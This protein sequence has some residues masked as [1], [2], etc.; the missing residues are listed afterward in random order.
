VKLRGAVFGC[1]MISEYHLAAWNRIPEVEIVALGNRTLSRAEQRRDQFAPYARVYSDIAEMLDREHPDFIDIL[2]APA[3]HREHC[4][5][6]REAGV[7][8]ICQKP[9][10][11]TLEDAFAIASMTAESDKLFAVHENHRYRPWFQ[12]ARQGVSTGKYGDIT[13]AKFEH[14]NATS[15]RELY[16][17]ESERGILL[18]YGSHLIDMMRSVLGEPARVYA[19]AHR[20]TAA[21][22]GESLAHAVFEYPSATAVV[23]VGWKHAAI[24]Q[25]SVLLSGTAGE[26][27]FE[28]T[29]TRGD[30]GRFRITHGGQVLLDEPRRPMSDYVES[31]YLLE[32][33]CVDV[34]LGRRAAPE[35]TAD[36]HLKT[37]ACTFAAYESIET[38]NIVETAGYYGRV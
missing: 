4:T 9:L 27:L 25:S 8:I 32:R 3:Q 2:T 37:L 18:E 33:E 38:G 1:G 7:H 19:R 5:I 36:E 15:P 11:E 28:G 30:A 14:L 23:E 6:A 16:K 10:A 13:L 22:R 24:T 26:A 21:V 20:I 31:F 17:Q 12:T 29:L 34:M 35:Q